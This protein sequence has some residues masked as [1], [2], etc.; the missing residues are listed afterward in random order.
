ME[1]ELPPKTA[2]T[3]SEKCPVIKKSRKPLLLGLI[4]PNL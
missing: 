1:E 3:H 2:K 4:K